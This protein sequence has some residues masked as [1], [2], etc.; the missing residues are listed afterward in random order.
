MEIPFAQIARQ[1]ALVPARP[2][3]LLYG[4]EQVLLDEV[5][6]KLVAGV[7]QSSIGEPEVQ[8]L[9]GP[10]TTAEQV[11]QELANLS[12]LSAAKVV[13]LR[14]AQ[15]M[16]APEQARLANLVP[17][18]GPGA[19]L[20]L[21]AG[22]PRYDAKTRQTKLLHDKLEPVVRAS[23]VVIEVPT[24]REQDAERWLLAEAQEAGIR[25][26]PRAAAQM[27]LLA[28]ADLTRLRHEL[29]K[30][31]AYA[32]PGRSVDVAD[33][34]LVVS[35]SPEA[36][37]FELTDAIGER[38][39]DRALQALEVLLDAGEPEPRILALI[40]RQIRLIWQAKY[41][42]EKGYLKR[43][44]SQ[45]PAAVARDLLPQEAS[46]S[47]MGQVQRPFLREKLLR[48]ASAF[49]WEGLRR[50]LERVLAAD[51]AFKGIEGDVDNPRLV[52]EMLVLEL[53]SSR[54][55]SSG[56]GRMR[57]HA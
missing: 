26:E 55:R 36:T 29:E 42:A 24:F 18:L 3:Y 49:T 30:V 33:V 22:E 32:G 38:R 35:R 45:V 21:I 25:M 5:L 34:Q 48:Q 28:G 4:R 6:A 39:P 52:L 43:S 19:L 16:R 57:A 13:V 11:G 44:G 31:V 12:L 7:R 27:V 51:L 56:S 40:A 14:E 46:L 15:R 47:V 9:F 17:R 8:T 50:G 54:R 10:G 23:G 2:V 1:P 37:V 20:V 41:L 53:A